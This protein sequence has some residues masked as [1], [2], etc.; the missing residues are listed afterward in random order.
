MFR[1]PI[2]LASANREQ[3]IGQNFRALAG[4]DDFGMELHG[5]K[6]PDW[7][8][9]GGDGAGAGGADHR[10]AAGKSGDHVAVAHP[11]LLTRGKSAEQRIGG[12]GVQFQSRQPEL[13]FIALQHRAVEQVSHQMQ[14]VANTQN[15]VIAAEYRRI[16]G[17]TA[18]VVHAARAA[19]YDQAFTSGQLAGGSFAGPHIGVDPQ[20]PDL[21]GNQVAILTTG[22]EY[23]DLGRIDGSR[24]IHHFM[25]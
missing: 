12:R 2:P 21:A 13:A 9:H 1:I 14:S 7:F 24:P 5:V 20:L 3:E 18:R 22:I 4:M 6:P 15:R 19:R 11:H 16:H 10:E 17:R 25:R 8:G 23:R